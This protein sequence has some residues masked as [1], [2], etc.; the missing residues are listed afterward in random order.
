S[1][2]AVQHSHTAFVLHPN[3]SEFLPE[4]FTHVSPVSQQ[5]FVQSLPFPKMFRNRIIHV[6][7]TFLG[8]IQREAL[9]SI[10]NYPASQ[11]TPSSLMCQGISG[12]DFLPCRYSNNGQGKLKS[13]SP[14]RS[15]CGTD[16][17]VDCLA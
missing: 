1:A 7:P 12:R 6:A 10:W 3:S 9:V 5:C 8:I 11:F 2:N 4:C 14:L 15:V 16:T 13:L 17:L